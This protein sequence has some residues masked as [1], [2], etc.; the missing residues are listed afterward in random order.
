LVVVDNDDN[1]V[2]N[3]V[4][5]GRDDDNN[6]RCLDDDDDDDEEA[7][8]VTTLPKN[9]RLVIPTFIIMLIF[10]GSLLACGHYLSAHTS[11]KKTN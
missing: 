2:D 1:A 6:I 3:D 8:L 7:L 4:D 5:N 9:L 11:L 10:F